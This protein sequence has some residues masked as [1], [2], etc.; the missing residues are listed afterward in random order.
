[1]CEEIQ[2]T[3]TCTLKFENKMGSMVLDVTFC[4]KFARSLRTCVG[5]LRVLRLPHRNMYIR[6]IL[7]D[8]GTGLELVGPR[9]FAVAASC[10]SGVGEMQRTSF[11]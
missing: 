5:F 10:S 1:M 7:C 9:G 2:N 11:S 8:R 4:G 3:L 6:L